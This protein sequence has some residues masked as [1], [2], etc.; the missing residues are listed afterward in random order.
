[1]KYDDVHPDFDTI[2]TTSMNDD[3][4]CTGIVLTDEEDFL[5]GSFNT[6]IVRV[7]ELNAQSLITLKKLLPTHNDTNTKTRYPLSISPIILIKEFIVHDNPIIS[8]DYTAFEYEEEY[9]SP[10]Q[11]EDMKI[12]RNHDDFLK[13]HVDPIGYIITSSLDQTTAITSI[14]GT[15]IGKFGIGKW[16]INNRS[17]WM[18]SNDN[19]NEISLA[20]LTTTLPKAPNTLKKS[21]AGGRTL[22]F[23]TGNNNNNSSNNNTTKSAMLNEYVDRLKAINQ[24][25]KPSF[26]EANK[27]YNQLIKNHPI[28]KI[29]EA[30]KK[31]PPRNKRT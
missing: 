23:A 27:L 7:W 19:K 6:G 16:D 5:I 30:S 25:K 11:L 17:T 9:I 3:V 12:T 31:S 18:K 13:P 29:K 14:D 24:N 28:D 1:M 26:S 15:I 20:L 2:I 10:E 8:I 21:T 4:I 22:S